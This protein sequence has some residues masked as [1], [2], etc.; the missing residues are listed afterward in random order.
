MACTCRTA[1]SLLRT[2]STQRIV[3]S[4]SFAST[5]SIPA[6]AS[7][8]TPPAASETAP[9]PS[10][11]SSSSSSPSIS[12]CP[13]GTILKGLNYLKDESPILSKL[14]SE[15]PTW[16]W[17]LASS[18]TGSL[19]GVKKPKNKKK[20]KESGQEDLVLED[21]KRQKKGLKTEG[22]KAIKASNALRG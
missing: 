3:S 14:D 11:T 16:L 6:P 13:E 22:R 5:S 17:S 12:S 2:R 15:Y 1:L 10:S 8:P 19:E 20:S 7:T 4:R 9:P 21:L 18:P